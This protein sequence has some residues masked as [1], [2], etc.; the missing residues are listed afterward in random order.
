MKTLTVKDKNHIQ[1]LRGIFPREIGVRIQRSQDGGFFAEI[2]KFDAKLYTEAETFSELIGM[3][4]DA[5]ITYF[6]IPKKYVSFMPNYIPPLKTAQ[7]FGV[8]PA[9]KK[10]KEIR[11]PLAL[12]VL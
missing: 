8:F 1:T 11:M 3:V 4:N 6:E 10:A 9:F 12:P 7:E 2:M 5:V